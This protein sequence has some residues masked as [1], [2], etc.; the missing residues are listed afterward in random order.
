M[1]V[2]CEE[3]LI[4]IPTLIDAFFIIFYYG[5]ITGNKIGVMVVRGI[6]MDHRW[7]RMGSREA[8]VS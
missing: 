5:V 8:V 1:L 3:G 7:V 4:F 2:D 6:K